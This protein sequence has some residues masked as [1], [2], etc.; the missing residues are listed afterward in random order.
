VIGGGVFAAGAYSAQ[1]EIN[2]SAPA[3]DGSGWFGWVDNRS[4]TAHNITAYAICAP[5]TT[6][7]PPVSAPETAK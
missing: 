5:V 6:W 4:A 7:V 1:Q 2:S 3:S